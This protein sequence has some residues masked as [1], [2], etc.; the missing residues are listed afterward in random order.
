MLEFDNLPPLR[1]Q[2]RELG[3]HG[4]HSRPDQSCPPQYWSCGDPKCCGHRLPHEKCPPE[5]RFDRDFNW[6]RDMRSRDHNF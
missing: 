5:L 6:K 1:F 4:L 3:C 2:C